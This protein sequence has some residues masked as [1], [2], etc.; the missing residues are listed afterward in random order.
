MASKGGKDQAP[1][2]CP[3]CGS[4]LAKSPMGTQAL[5]AVAGMARRIHP[6]QR[7]PGGQGGQG[8]R[9]PGG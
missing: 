1:P 4:Q 9:R 8:P 7:G 5:H 6:G 2:V 3:M